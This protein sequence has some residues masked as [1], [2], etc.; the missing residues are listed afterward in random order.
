MLGCAIGGPSAAGPFGFEVVLQDRVDGG[1]RAS[2]DLQR[3]A[4]GCL[5]PVAA[6]ALDQPD[7]AD[8]GPESLLRVRA[9]AHDRLDQRRGIAP[10]LAGLPPDPPPRPP[11]PTPRAARPVPRRRPWAPR[12]GWPGGPKAIAYEP[13][14]GCRDGRPRWY[15]P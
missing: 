7:D 8:R 4:A 6:I 15:A 3:T 2:A 1:E 12:R 9:L 14:P 11:R 13:R 5:Q 10:D